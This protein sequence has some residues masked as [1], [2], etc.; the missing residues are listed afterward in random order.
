[1]MMRELKYIFFFLSVVFIASPACSQTKTDAQQKPVFRVSDQ[2]TISHAQMIDDLKQGQIVFAGESHDNQAHHQLQLDIIKTL[3]SSGRPLAVGFEMF[4]EKSQGF[5]DR[6]VSGNLSQD[7]FIRVYYENW[8]F[9]WPLYRDI[10]LYLKDN[11]IP[12]IGLNVE[13]SITRK[14][15]QSGFASLTKEELKKLPPDVGCAVDKHYM[16][17]IRRAYATHGHGNREFLFF[18]Q[19]QLLWDQV[20]ER[21]IVSF[22][23]KNPERTIIV[24]TGNGHAWKRGIPEQVR[25]LSDQFRYRVLLP[26]IPG[27]IDSRFITTGDADYL[28]SP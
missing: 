12:A 13:P 24:I 20:M 17:F 18:C 9:P 25:L 3:H 5:L 8:N 2:K 26:F 28:L 19:A 27:H 23:Q 11:K 21:N 1:M 4:T 14:V 7:E 15:S 10:L 16:D 6:W 22:L